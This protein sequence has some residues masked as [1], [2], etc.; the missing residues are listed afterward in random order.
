RQQAA[1]VRTAQSTAAALA[2]V[3]EWRP[4]VILTDI[5][6]PGE[7]GYALAERLHAL[8]PERGGATPVVAVTAHGRVED[9]V[10]SASAGFDLHLA[11]PVD[12]S[13]LI[14]VVANLTRRR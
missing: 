6:L 4:H 8:P 12:A 5:E 3:P 11:K 14:A 10:R 1:D 13:E 2:I 9:R 7:D